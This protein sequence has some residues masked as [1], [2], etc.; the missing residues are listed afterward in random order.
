[1]FFQDKLTSLSVGV[2]AQQS[3]YDNFSFH[4]HCCCRHDSYTKCTIHRWPTY[5]WAQLT[6]P[7]FS[8]SRVLG[9]QLAGFEQMHLLKKKIATGA[10]DEQI[11]LA[12]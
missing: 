9:E 1:M 7:I 2:H 12:T 3:C 10:T 6:F 4:G 11:K 5:Y 8:I